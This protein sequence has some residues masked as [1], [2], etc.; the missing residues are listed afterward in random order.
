MGRV[1][2]SVGKTYNTGNYTSLR[3]DIGFEEDVEDYKNLDK[4][5]KLMKKKINDQLHQFEEEN[6][7]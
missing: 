5:I 6:G 7:V 2:I 4:S 1:K 3:V